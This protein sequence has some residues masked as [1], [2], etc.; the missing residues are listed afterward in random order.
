[1]L[2]KYYVIGDYGPQGDQSIIRNYL[3]S[4]PENAR[5]MFA[6]RIKRESEYLWSRIGDRNISVYSGWWQH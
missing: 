6:E 3:A 2:S 5:L 1:M 4:S